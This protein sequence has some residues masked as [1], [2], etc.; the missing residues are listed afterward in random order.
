M[1]NSL[2][3]YIEYIKDNPEGYWF[4]AKLY[5]WGWMPATWEGWLTFLI[6]IG[7]MAGN[8]YRLEASSLSEAEVIKELIPQTLFLILL[9][10][11]ICW[12]TGE[13]PRWQFGIPKKD[14]KKKKYD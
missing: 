2:K 11:A 1:A 7:L 3:E 9:L 6:F 13:R 10:T 5:G 12:R 8:A 4:K 14:G